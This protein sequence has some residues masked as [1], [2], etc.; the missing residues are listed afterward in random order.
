M[1]LGEVV[2][3]AKRFARA[4]GDEVMKQEKGRKQE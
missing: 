3:D 4:S 1:K 2:V